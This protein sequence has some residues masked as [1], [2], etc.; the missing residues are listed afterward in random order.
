MLGVVFFFPVREI[1]YFLFFFWKGPAL[2]SSIHGKNI[3]RTIWLPS[4]QMTMLNAHRREPPTGDWY[5]DG[6]PRKWL[7]IM[8]FPDCRYYLPFEIFKNS[9]VSY[10]YYTYYLG[11]HSFK[12]CYLYYLHYVY[13]LCIYILPKRH[14]FGAQICPAVGLIVTSHDNTSQ[15]SEAV[16]MDHSCALAL[17]APE[18]A[19]QLNRYVSEGLS[20]L[21]GFLKGAKWNRTT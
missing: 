15:S 21:G 5:L 13:I 11:F 2:P 14:T 18:R 19:D 20:G 16:T 10:L 7:V 3:M 8:V 4:T 17:P 9:Y 1:S 6:Y 12:S